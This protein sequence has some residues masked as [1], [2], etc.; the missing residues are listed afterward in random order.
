MNLQVPENTVMSLQV[1]ENTVM[2][3]QVPAN[4]VMSLQVPENTVMSLHVPENTVMS[5]HV[6]ENTV[7]SLQVPE[8]MVMSLQVPENTVMS[9]QVPENTGNFLT[10]TGSITKSSRTLIHGVSQLQC[11]WFESGHDRAMLPPNLLIRSVSLSKCRITYR[12][13]ISRIT[14]VALN[15]EMYISQSFIIHK[16]KS[17]KMQQCFKI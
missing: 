10:S 8:N 7:T 16:E 4:T 15:T 1:P 14:E 2:S 12:R 3:L 9:L 11:Q 6:P 5:L 13:S 17:N